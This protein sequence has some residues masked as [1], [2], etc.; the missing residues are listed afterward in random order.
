[1]R[2][3]HKIALG[4]LLVLAASVFILKYLVAYLLPFLLAVLL[5][6]LIE[7]A[8]EFL[9]REAKLARGIAVA[10]VL[11]VILIIVGLLLTVAVSRLFIELDSLINNLP[12]YQ[13]IGQKISWLAQQ[14]QEFD[15]LIEEL[16]MPETV[17][18]SINNNLEQI[19]EQARTY[20]QSAITFLLNLVKQLPTLITMLLIS[21]VATFFISRDKELIVNTY[22]TPFSADWQQQIK[23]VQNR[24]MA[25]AVGF[26]RAQTILI[27]M[28]TI[29]AIIG[30]TLLRSNYA[31][32]AGLVT[33]ILDL[34]PVIG[35]GM[36]LV[37]WAIYSLLIGQT[38]FGL[39]VFVLYVLITVI[40]QAAE[41]KIVGESIGV[42]PLITLLAMYLGVQFFGPTG[43]FIGPAV[44]IV[45]KSILYTDFISFI[46]PQ[47]E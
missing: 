17:K 7:P 30:L 18:N 47:E 39:G 41:A 6:S 25:A 37:P 12:D 5:A 33:G 9:T 11:I 27:S 16:K 19:Y 24:I 45:G 8:V 23:Q 2:E 32:V 43:F 40:R 3:I 35:P 21:L 4:F 1:M 46:I 29:L 26:I 28:S 42:H 14:N 34:I 38:K 15:Q 13:T 31:L 10:I 44:V 22:L 20:I 36:I